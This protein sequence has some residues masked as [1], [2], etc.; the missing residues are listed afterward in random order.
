ME[1]LGALLQ[2][3]IAGNTLIV[4]IAIC[5]VGIYPIFSTRL[6]DHADIIG[7]GNRSGSC[8][9]CHRCGGCCRGCVC[10]RKRFF[11]RGLHGSRYYG[12][13]GGNWCR[14][15]GSEF[16]FGTLDCLST[17]P[18]AVV[19]IISIAVDE[20]AALLVLIRNLINYHTFALLKKN[21]PHLVTR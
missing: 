13:Y 10:R 4:V 9:W 12:F 11:G 17:I 16:I 18:I 20:L 15:L 1:I 19:G 14:S 5:R 21:R 8:G 7:I 6:A 3:K 2:K